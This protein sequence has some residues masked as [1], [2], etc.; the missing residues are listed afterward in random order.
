ML[1]DWYIEFWEVNCKVY[2]WGLEFIKLGVCCSD[3]VNELNELYFEYDLLKYCMFGYG[4][5]FGVFFYYYGCEVGLEICEDIEM[6][7]YLNMVVFMELMIIV[8]ERE[9]GVG[10]YREYDILVVKE[11]DSENIIKFLYGLEY[12]IIKN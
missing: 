7:L 9:F 12:N 3:I 10:G 8:F 5:F 6:V 1:L 4:Y 11:I 2:C